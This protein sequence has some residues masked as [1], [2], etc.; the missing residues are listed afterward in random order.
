MTSLQKIYNLL[1]KKFGPQNWWPI[2]DSTGKS[3]YILN[4]PKNKEERLEIILGAI[5]T[6]NTSWKNVEKALLNLKRNNLLTKD[7]LKKINIKRLAKLIKSSGYHNQKAKK[8]K[9]FVKF[10][11][12]NKKITRD[13][14]LKIWGIGP[15]TADSI[16]LYAHNKPYFVID[17][18]TKRIMNRLG[19]K[20]KTYKEFQEL[21]HKSLPKNYKIYN[22]FH[23]LLVKLAKE[24]CKKKPN[25]NN[26]PI[27]QYCN[28][29][30]FYLS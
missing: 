23:S 28:Y 13:N 26:C 14:L 25:C 7:K 9:E 1:C 15:E 16:L 29:K 10:L 8:I 27:N 19:Y 12:S 17:A 24:H 4:A 18:Y 3:I 20:E 6:Q 30:S 2:L 5:L 21:F 11:N 22:E